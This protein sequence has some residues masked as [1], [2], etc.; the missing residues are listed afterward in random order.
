MSCPHCG[1]EFAAEVPVDMTPQEREKQD[2][3]AVKA[4]NTS[5][6]EEA[7]MDLEKRL[8]ELEDLVAKQATK[9]Q[10]EPVET[11]EEVAKAEGVDQSV[12]KVIALATGDQAELIEKTRSEMSEGLEI[13]GKAIMEIREA[14]GNLPTGRKSVARILPPATG[15]EGVEKTAEDEVIEKSD[16]PVEVLKALNAKT[17]GIV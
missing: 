1:H 2:K 11:A 4:D 9:E 5:K 7:T 6:S 3:A 17:Y 16:D 8:K 14:F 13:V 15:H 10:K 12:L